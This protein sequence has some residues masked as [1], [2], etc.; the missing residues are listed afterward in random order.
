MDAD[1]STKL[2]SEPCATLCVNLSG[3]YYS[4]SVLQLIHVMF[5]VF[6]VST[7]GSIRRE[8]V[9]FVVSESTFL[10]NHHMF[11]VAYPRNLN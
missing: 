5:H 4:P 11:T 9:N 10:K 1:F 6:F 8:V 2:W 7:A 3:L